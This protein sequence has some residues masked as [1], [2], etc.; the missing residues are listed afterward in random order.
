[1]STTD[2]STTLPTRP[3]SADDLGFACAYCGSADTWI[4]YRLEV[5]PWGTYLLAGVQTKYAAKGHPYAVCGGCGHVSRG[6]Q[7]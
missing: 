1:M 2:A 5:V 4:E 7:D 6:R 3:D